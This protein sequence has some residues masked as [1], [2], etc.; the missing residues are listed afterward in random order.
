MRRPLKSHQPPRSLLRISGAAGTRSRNLLIATWTGLPLEARSPVQVSFLPDLTAHRGKLL[1]AANQ[2]TPVFA[3]SFIRQRRI[4]LETGLRSNAA[5][6]QFIFV[7]EVFHFA[8]VRLGNPARQE[9]SH[10]L[11]NE[12]R[13]RARGELGES[14]AVKKA[15]LHTGRELSSSSKLWRDYV[16][17]SFCDS[18]ACLFVG[19]PVHDG[20]R[21]GKRWSAL[22]R[23]WFLGKMAGDARWAV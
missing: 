11:T 8:W 14:S 17:E 18:A 12:L 13:H 2:G 3:A 10:L 19:G 1:S 16:C 21:L 7:H 6:L 5:V 9:Y 20:A 15:E 22:R 4:V 23:D